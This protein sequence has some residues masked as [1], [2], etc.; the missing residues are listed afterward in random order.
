M[1]EFDRQY[2]AYVL[3]DDTCSRDQLIPRLQ[4]LGLSVA[5]FNSARD[6][7]AHYDRC[8]RGCLILEMKLPGMTGLEL[9]DFLNQH[10][11][12]LPVIFFTASADVP[13]AVRAIQNGAVDCIAK[14]Q[15][16]SR[17]L[18]TVKRVMGALRSGSLQG[19]AR[20]PYAPLNSGISWGHP[21]H[22]LGR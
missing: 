4:S 1:D 13:S 22:S 6:F 20:H 16:P 18:G 2:I 11:I 21:V 9:Q 5:A 14:T 3:D 8:S 19:F 10:H 15:E 7:L 12:P 17:L